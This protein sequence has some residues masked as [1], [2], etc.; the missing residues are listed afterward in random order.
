MKTSPIKIGT[1][2]SP[3]ALWQANEVARLINAPFEIVPIVTSGDWKPSHGDSPL[4]PDA[5]GKA[6]FTKE[7]EAALFAGEIDCAVH[8]VKDMEP[9]CVGLKYALP[10]GDAFDAIVGT[11]F[12]RIGTTSPRRAMFAK[13]LWPNAQILPIRGNVETRLKKLDDGQY[14]TIILAA[15]GLQRL[16]LAHRITRIL[17]AHE[18]L[19]AAGQGAIGIQALRDIDALAAI[20]CDDTM[21]CITAERAAVAKLDGNCQSAIGAHATII[22]GDVVLKVEHD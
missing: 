9:N 21:R 10:R 17:G 1:R 18:M 11:G 2:G 12:T 3:L 22:N 19:P 13:K 16:G 5:G 6:L 4:N 20:S 8:S 15:A 14:D 7:I